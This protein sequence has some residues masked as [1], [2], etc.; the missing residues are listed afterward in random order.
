MSEPYSEQLARV[1]LMASGSPTWDL[2]PNDLAALNAVLQHLDMRDAM[3]KVMR[4]VAGDVPRESLEL[5]VRLG[6]EMECFSGGRCAEML[7]TCLQDFRER[8][9]VQSRIRDALV[10]AH[11]RCRSDDRLKGD[12]EQ[13]LKDYE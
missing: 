6:Y 4:Q 10:A 2:S 12:I 13:I 7:E 9:W 5:L 3:I 11:E 8:G 1:R